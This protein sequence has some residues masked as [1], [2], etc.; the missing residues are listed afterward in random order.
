MDRTCGFF[1]KGPRRLG[2]PYD[3][4]EA[5]PLLKNPLQKFFQIDLPII[6]PEENYLTTSH[7]HKGVEK[8]DSNFLCAHVKFFACDTAVCS[9]FIRIAICTYDHVIMAEWIGAVDVAL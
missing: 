4:A 7:K 2:F 9:V 3:L 1:V 8:S 5:M 6:I